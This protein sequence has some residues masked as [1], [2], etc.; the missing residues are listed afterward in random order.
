MND[1]QCAIGLKQLEKKEYIFSRKREN[2]DYYVKRLKDNKHLKIVFPKK[3]SGHVPFR[4]A[5]VFEDHQVQIASFLAE[6]GIETRTFFYPLH[7]QPC[8]KYLNQDDPTDEYFKASN[9]LFDSGLCFPV[10]P[11]LTKEKVDYICDKIEE[12]YGGL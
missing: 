8:F 10:Y 2:F 3:E 9:K 12:F 4:V 11:D 5:I 1:L 6:N 7:K